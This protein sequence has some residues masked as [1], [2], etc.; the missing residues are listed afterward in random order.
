MR[1]PAP[2]LGL[3]AALLGLAVLPYPQQARA[4]DSYTVK[5]CVADAA[6][7]TPAPDVVVHPSWLANGQIAAVQNVSGAV[8]PDLAKPPPGRLFYG[9]PLCVVGPVVDG[10]V[11]PARWAFC[12]NYPLRACGEAPFLPSG[13][14]RGGRADL[15]DR[16]RARLAH[17]LTA[18]ADYTDRATRRRTQLLVWCVTEGLGANAPA[19][20]GGPYGDLKCPDWPSVDPTLKTS[21]KI[22]VTAA[23]EP[24]EPGAE[25][26]FPVASDVRRTRIERS[27]IDTLT[28]CA[29]SPGTLVDGQLELP[30]GTGRTELCGTR[31]ESGT[32][33]VRAE[34]E[35]H[36]LTSMEFLVTNGG[37]DDCQGFVTSRP[38]PRAL[39][40]QAEGTWRRPTRP[41]PPVAT[42]PVATPP[43]PTP[44]T[45]VPP[46]LTP[47]VV[48]LPPV[49]TPPVVAVP[50]RADEVPD[51]QLPV[52]DP[53]VVAP[54]VLVPPVAV[55]PVVDPPV[56][57]PP[58][59]VPPGRPDSTPDP[60]PSPLPKPSQAPSQPPAQPSP[61][62]S[63]PGVT[64]PE[65]PPTG[66]TPVP[67][68]LPDT[69]APVTPGQGLLAGALLVAVGAGSVFASR[70]GKRARA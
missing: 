62:A 19:P 47:P 51:P 23:Q 2:A 40:S 11:T 33:T 9:V 29:G 56:A 17:V 48:A 44:Q 42:P 36:T 63:D 5:G 7:G 53:P 3:A 66:D 46:V 37:A 69:G 67:P 22:E 50:P 59:A 38:R 32:G 64:P 52:L 65:Q 68:Q 4:V 43:E 58:V 24:A 6:G 14:T 8:N 10:V 35:D 16:D 34:A 49:L 25:L 41:T 57:V 1:R 20:E 12:M 27:G 45:P 60:D 13:S 55:P 21:P 39:S 28:V 31:A 54:P 18:E 26:R 70:R 30:A 15:S 61:S